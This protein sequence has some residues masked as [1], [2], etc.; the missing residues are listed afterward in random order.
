MQALSSYVYIAAN[1]ILNSSKDAQSRHL[2][3]LFPPLIPLLTSHHHSLRGFTQVITCG[4]HISVFLIYIDLFHIQIDGSWYTWLCLQLLVYQILHKL[5]PQ[6][7]YGSSEMLPLEKRC[8]V[9]L[10]TY[11]ARNSDCARYYFFVFLVN[12]VYLYVT[13]VLS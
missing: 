8:F 12:V 3:E 6:L 10:K 11:L 7:N 13:I 4:V 5:F 1:I 9:D 2:D